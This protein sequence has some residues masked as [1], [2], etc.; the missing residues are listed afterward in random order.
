[1]LFLLLLLLL[2]VLNAEINYTSKYVCRN[3]SAA[4]LALGT[5]NMSSVW[6]ICNRIGYSNQERFVGAGKLG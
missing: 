5:S 1:M 3:L 2:C 4:W 6:G